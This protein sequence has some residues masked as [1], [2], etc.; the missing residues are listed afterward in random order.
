[1]ALPSQQLA[2]QPFN[3]GSYII[4]V[5]YWTFVNIVTYFVSYSLLVFPNTIFLIASVTSIGTSLATAP[6]KPFQVL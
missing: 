5:L 3:F 2:N 6:E 4:E 1:M